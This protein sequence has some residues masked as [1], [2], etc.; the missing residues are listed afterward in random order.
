MPRFAAN[1]SMM[2]TEWTFL[3][4]FKAAAES[5]FGAVEFLFPYDHAPEAV[6]AALADNRLEQA[7][8]NLPPGDWERGERGMASHPGRKSEFRASVATALVYARAGG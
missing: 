1:L 2:F 4:R 3:D 5:G 7:L 8:F 6:A